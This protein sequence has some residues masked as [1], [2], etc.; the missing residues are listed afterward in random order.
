MFFFI[1]GY[2]RRIFCRH[3]IMFMQRSAR[4]ITDKDMM[5]LNKFVHNRLA[6]VVELIMEER[7]AEFAFMVEAQ[8]FYGSEWDQIVPDDGGMKERFQWQLEV[9]AN[10]EP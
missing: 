9:S 4:S 6:Y 10:K 1:I 2:T 5:I 7:A 8:K 3:F